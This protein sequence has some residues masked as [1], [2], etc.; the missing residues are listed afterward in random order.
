MGQ[1]RSK[2]ETEALW[3]E[4]IAGLESSGLTHKAWCEQNRISET[5]LRYWRRR[6]KGSKTAGTNPKGFLR[7]VA[8]P[9]SDVPTPRIQPEGAGVTIKAVVIEFAETGVTESVR[10]ALRAL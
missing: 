2:D 1:K 5:T 10:E 8:V 4:R 9:D 7:A 6:L 3:K